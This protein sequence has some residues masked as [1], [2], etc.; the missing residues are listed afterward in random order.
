[1]RELI[2]E[3]YFLPEMFLNC[4]GHDFGVQ[5]N[6]VRVD[7]VELPEWCGG[8]PYRFVVAHR[9]ELEGEYVST[10]LHQWIDLVFGYKQRDEDL[11]TFFHLTYEDC[12]VLRNSDERDRVS[13]ES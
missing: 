5:Q 7:N 4:T 3:F 1:M 8:D 9:L 13:Y 6:G 12:E 2:P 11:N 10:N